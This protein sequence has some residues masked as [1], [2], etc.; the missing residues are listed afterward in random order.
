MRTTPPLPLGMTV[1][2]GGLGVGMGVGVGMDMG[3]GLGTLSNTPPLGGVVDSVADAA[4]GSV[5]DAVS[6]HKPSAR[7]LLD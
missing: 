5:A 6:S 4:T 7:S 2:M 3:L 1:G